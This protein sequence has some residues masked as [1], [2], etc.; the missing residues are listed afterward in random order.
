[1]RKAFRRYSGISACYQARLRT[2]V[3]QEMRLRSKKLK[4]QQVTP[5]VRTR[6]IH[7]LRQMI[8]W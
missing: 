2:F 8:S 3:A 5:L 1:M 4:D 7:F 6:Y